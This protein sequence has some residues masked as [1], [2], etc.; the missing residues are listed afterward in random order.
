MGGLMD[1]NSILQLRDLLAC[2]GGGLS[3]D[4]EDSPNNENQMHVLWLEF[5][6]YALY[7]IP[8]TAFHGLADEIERIC[9]ILNL[10]TS[11]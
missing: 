5:G 11:T 2:I 7:M 4:S 1:P 3:S 10:N 6:L 8:V 9:Q